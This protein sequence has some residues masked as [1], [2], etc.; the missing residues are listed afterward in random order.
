MTYDSYKARSIAMIESA[1]VRGA[2]GAGFPTHKKASGK[3]DI[4]IANGIECEPVLAKDKAIMKAYP[5][6]VVAG[7]EMMM[8]LVGAER[9]VIAVKRKNAA[10]VAAMKAAV[11]SAGSGAG[12]SGSAASGPVIASA[13]SRDRI[14]VAEMD[15]FYPAGDEHVLVYEVTGRLVPAGGIPLARGVVVNNVE[16]LMNVALAQGG[17][18][19]TRKFVTVAGE[20]NRPAT[21]RVAIGTT[22]AHLLELAGGVRE[23]HRSDFEVMLDG[24][25]M[26]RVLDRGT[27]LGAVQ[28]SA[29][30]SGV[31]VLPT[32]H[33]SL[34]E[35]RQ[36]MEHQV[37]MARSACIQCTMCTD[38]CPRYLLGHE[39]RPHI[40]MRTIGHAAD[41]ALADRPR[42]REELLM[43]GLCTECGVCSLVC[44][45]GLAPRSVN[46]RVRRAMA[47]GG[48]R[49]N[50]LSGDDGTRVRLHPARR[51]RLIP[52]G[53]VAAR[54]RL[55]Q[56]LHV[57][58]LA[59]A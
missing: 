57:E 19:V 7:L 53:R 43:A 52:S 59:E 46:A 28:V 8:R 13:A 37:R 40:I 51:G 24:P 44:P 9:G 39:L 2:G 45:M 49:W 47:A 42:E 54:L 34:T 21:Y 29:I 38:A 1:G 11:A 23:E 35:R 6:L 33:P 27:D 3:A 25:M 10:E 5:E 58:E 55:G 17:I 56:Y 30:T 48:L 16:T 36:S 14:T 18:A 4:V 41:P 20:V 50:T 22:V 31:I 15:D 26:G 12:A 32:R